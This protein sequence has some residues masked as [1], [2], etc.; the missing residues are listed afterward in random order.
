MNKNCLLCGVG[1]QG[2][3]L[4]S[5]LIAYAA[6]DK[7]MFVRT[8]ETIGMAQRGGSV[9]SHVRMGEGIHSPLI[10]KGQADIILAFEPAEAVR[11]LD[12]LKPGGTLVVNKK[13]VK[14]VTATLSEMTYD[15]TEMIEYLEKTVGNLL[16]VDGEDICQKAGSSKVLNT[17]LLGAA[18]E[19]GILAVS[20]EDMKK[21]MKKNVRPEFI[22]LNEKA[23]ELGANEEVKRRKGLCR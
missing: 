9:V 2:V 14:P 19:S 1:G 5:K 15:G 20:I 6:I 7:G 22:E 12:F 8:T 16:I 21:E 3:V 4:A 23:L 17:A 13:A 10:P 11:N 18:A